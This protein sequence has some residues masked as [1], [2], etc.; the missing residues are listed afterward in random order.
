M[1]SYW[2]PIRQVVIRLTEASQPLRPRQVSIAELRSSEDEVIQLRGWAKSLDG[3]FVD[4]LR[5][6]PSAV[7]FTVP[8]RWQRDEAFGLVALAL[9]AEVVRRHGDEHEVWPSV[10]DAFS[11]SVCSIAFDRNGQPSTLLKSC[12]EAGAERFGLRHAFD[13][14]AVRQRWYRTVMLQVAFTRRQ[15]ESSLPSWLDRLTSLPAALDELLLPGTGSPSLQATWEALRRLRTAVSTR[16]AT[17]KA[18]A[19]DGWI[20]PAW[21]DATLEAATRSRSGPAAKP[22]E[23]TEHLVEDVALAWPAGQKPHFAARAVR[24]SRLGLGDL[25]RLQTRSELGEVLWVRA[26]GKLEAL[27]GDALQ[28]PVAPSA[29]VTLH[30]AHDEVLREEHV[31]LLALDSGLAVFTDDALA[32]QV[33]LEGPLPGNVTSVLLV[34]RAD[35]E[36]QPKTLTS[37]LAQAGQ[38]RVHRVPVSRLADVTV[39]F[40]ES[41]LWAGNNVLE[42]LGTSSG[43]APSL[44]AELFPWVYAQSARPGPAEAWALAQGRP[45]VGGRARLRLRAPA[46]WQPTS[47]LV[48]GRPFPATSEL[49]SRSALN[50]FFRELNLEVRLPEPARFEP[51]GVQRY[52]IKAPCRRGEVQRMLRAEAKA[53]VVGAAWLAPHGWRTVV[54]DVPWVLDDVSVRAAFRFVGADVAKSAEVRLLEGLEPGPSLGRGEAAPGVLQKLRGIGERLDVEWTPEGKKPAQRVPLVPAA[55]DRGAVSDLVA[56]DDETV[57]VLLA[58]EHADPMPFDARRALLVWS[59]P[60]PPRLLRGAVDAVTALEPS[61]P[62]ERPRWRLTWPADTH[63]R[64]PLLVAVA[65]QGRRQGLF[66]S[67]DAGQALRDAADRAVLQKGAA[68][69]RLAALVRWLRPPVLWSALSGAVEHLAL[70]GGEAVLDVWCG[71]GRAL[72]PLLPAGLVVRADADDAWRAALR[73]VAKGL[74]TPTRAAGDVD[75]RRAAIAQRL[76]SRFEGAA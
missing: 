61:G 48:D 63:G 36:V 57:D 12:L 6:S 18:V 27:G 42:R 72:A 23:A 71:D 34:T 25:R 37:C 65:Y 73:R 67:E 5:Q 40:G 3:P 68:L 24:P 19:T 49:R 21:T 50:P 30:D 62:G 9:I 17:R 39:A 76:N 13:A 51:G 53:G 59:P 60:S 38:V 4:M 66:V 43:D 47:V 29:R 20:L 16:D 55:I 56:G 26:A 35:L 14:L 46:G 31:P 10:G 44:T 32:R 28:L 1:V 22:E 52:E 70:L 41:L 54:P 45:L 69:R 74:Q 7:A 64:A 2:E 11:I 58:S 75:I 8:D 15:L 33:P